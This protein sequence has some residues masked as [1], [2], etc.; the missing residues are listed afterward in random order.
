MSGSL[1]KIHLVKDQKYEA[2]WK[3][4]DRRARY[5]LAQRLESNLNNEAYCG[6]IMRSKYV[7]YDPA[8]T[9]CPDC[10]KA[11]FNN[12]QTNPVKNEPISPADK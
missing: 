6:A 4:G 9:T 10:L 8:R 1:G 11:K 12:R 5:L 7:T 3:N 2:V